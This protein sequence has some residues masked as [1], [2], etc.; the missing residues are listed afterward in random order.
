M[1]QQYEDLSAFSSLRDLLNRTNLCTVSDYPPRECGI[2]TFT[3]DLIDAIHQFTPFSQPSVVAVNEPGGIHRYPRERVRY[4]IYQDVPESYIQAAE[5]INDHEEFDGVSV[6]H[7]HG[8]YGGAAGVYLS[9]L[10]CRV[11]KPIVTTLHTVLKKPSEDEKRSIQEVFN[12]SDAVV[13]MVPAAR[14]LLRDSYEVDIKKLHIIPHGVPNIRRIPLDEAKEEFGLSGRTVLATF[15]LLSRGKGIEYAIEAVGKLAP[16]HPEILY[17][18]LG[19]T[20]PV[21][22]RHQGEEYRNF[23]QDRVK[24]LGIEKNV[25]FDNRY[26]SL[27][28]I[29]DYMNATD[30]FITPYLNPD[31][32]VSG[33]LS[34]A[35]GCG[36]AI[37]STKYLYAQSVLEGKG[38]LV[39]FESGD[40]I[41]E[42]VDRL[43]SDPEYRR[44]VEEESFRYGRRTTWHN[45]AIEYLNLYYQLS[46]RAK[47][48]AEFEP[49]AVEAVAEAE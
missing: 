27:E 40:A 22:R 30:V 42:G 41:A 44:E 8:I 38:V 24:E 37:V 20:H 39:D 29:I 45:V 46:G 31:Q 5:W 26:L 34:Y 1:A 35:L 7:E 3:R 47:E 28:E 9:E 21:V 16:K 2:A 17:L 43:L 14:D 18:V 48:P 4:Q 32:I 23:L 15:G 25:V 11:K 6:Q 33:V 12:Y 10:L 13:A 49:E 19:Q 36:K